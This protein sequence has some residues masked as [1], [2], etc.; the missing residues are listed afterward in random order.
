[1][2]AHRGIILILFT[3]QIAFII[4]TALGALV[5]DASFTSVVSSNQG[6]FFLILLLEDCKCYVA[7]IIIWKVIVSAATVLFC[8][9]HI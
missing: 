5:S 1:M 3:F 6:N 7:E 4:N 8:S 2:A 9:L